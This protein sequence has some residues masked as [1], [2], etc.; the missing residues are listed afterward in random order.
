MVIKAKYLSRVRTV[1]KETKYC[2]A[3]MIIMFK[4]TLYPNR[5]PIRLNVDISGFL[6]EWLR[7][8]RHP[9]GRGALCIGISKMAVSFQTYRGI[10]TMV[11]AVL[12]T[13]PL[14]QGGHVR[15]IPLISGSC[16]SV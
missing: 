4:C 8:S 10:H 3:T 16:N 5:L 11:Q 14:C 15:P 7:I 9:V 12:Q 1:D 6:F 13:S 2:L